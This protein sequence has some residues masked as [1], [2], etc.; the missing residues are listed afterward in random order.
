MILARKMVMA[1]VLARMHAHLLQARCYCFVVFELQL[2][3]QQQIKY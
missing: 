2:P 1:G 3:Q